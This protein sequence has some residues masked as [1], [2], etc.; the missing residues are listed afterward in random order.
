[1][2][3]FFVYF[4]FAEFF[5]LFDHI[6]TNAIFEL[7]KKKNRINLLGVEIRRYIITVLIYSVYI[8]YCVHF[9]IIRMQE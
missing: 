4:L 8:L 9:T 3:Y 5:K 2:Y 7:K 6:I 1:M